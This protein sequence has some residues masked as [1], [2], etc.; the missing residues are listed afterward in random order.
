MK[1]KHLFYS[2]ALAG[3]FA[4]CTQDELIE[5]PVAE[6]NVANRPVAG[7][8]EFTLGDGVDSRFNYEKQNGFEAGDVFGLYLMDEYVGNYNGSND[9]YCPN[10]HPNANDPYWKYQNH[11]WA[12]Y[13]LTNNIQSNYPFTATQDGDDL[14][15]K[16]DAKLVEGNYFAM[17]PQNDLALN[18]RELWRVIDAEVELKAHSTKDAIFHNVENQFWLG[19]QQIYRDATASAESVLKMNVKMSNVLV[20]L[21]FK[22][23]NN[24]NNTVILD[25]ISFVNKLGRHLPTL[26]YVEPAGRNYTNA[27]G[28]EVNNENGYT[29]PSWLVTS[30]AKDEFECSEAKARYLYDAEKTWT[31]ATIQ[32]IVRWSVPG[33]EAG[34]IPYGLTGELA[35]PAY[36]YSFSYP[37]DAALLPGGVDGGYLLTTYLVVPGLEDEAQWKDLMVRV[38]G[39][40]KDNS[41]T[42]GWTYGMLT[43]EMKDGNTA[44][45][46]FTFNLYTALTADKEQAEETGYYR[47]VDIKFQEFGWKSIDKRMEVA[48]TDEMEKKVLAHLSQVAD[49]ATARIKIA[50]DADGIEITKA[51]V[52]ALSKDSEDNGHVIE[53]EF[54]GDRGG[55][56]IFNEDNTL[57][58]LDYTT[59][60]TVGE[61]D[62]LKFRYTRGI[63]LVNNAVQTIPAGYTVE[64]AIIR[65][66]STGKLNVEGVIGAIKE[67]ESVLGSVINEGEMVVTGTI[68][69]NVSNDY[70]LTLKK[71]SNL[72]TVL[73]NN[74]GATTN[75]E[76]GDGVATVNELYNMGEYECS[77]C[78]GA[79]LNVVNGTLNVNYLQ[80]GSEDSVAATLEVA[81]GAILTINE[82]LTN[83]SDIDW[84]NNEWIENVIFNNNG[85]IN[86]EGFIE[87]NG[88]INNYGDINCQRI[89]NAEAAIINQN[90]ATVENGISCQLNNS[91]IIN[92]YNGKL[93][94]LKNNSVGILNVYTKTVEVNT[95][96]QSKGEI[97]FWGVDPEHIGVG[98]NDYRSFR[99]IKAMETK[100]LFPMMNRT[101]TDRLY[102]GY[103]LTLTFAE[104][105]QIASQITLIKV[106]ANAENNKV[107]ITGAMNGEFAFEKAYLDVLSG[108]QLHIE[109]CIEVTI[110]DLNDPFSGGQ[111]HVGS[112]SKLED[113]EGE[114]ITKH[115]SYAE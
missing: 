62:K 37:K 24:S 100:E 84:V 113:P 109:N 59:E 51:F 29:W 54:S 90:G 98:G 19:Y 53:L 22:L 92:A 31:R 74:A 35:R 95:T 87:N 4:A 47:N 26:A 96:N 68:N 15:W 107:N 105:N 106:F 94:K 81:K 18:R 63:S 30:D 17:F 101:A 12:M 52:E 8:V 2:L 39:W 7:V 88:T 55:K 79:T 69:V 72:T 86:G 28:D 73:L 80:N 61:S 9:A 78:I 67:N 33:A 111:I 46:N 41:S 40:Y 97:I 110:K 6:N 91:G 114:A 112:N 16:N 85:T 64:S 66:A 49:G 115:T 71:G 3:I 43:P 32:E 21:R 23:N 38:Y 50:P 20:P 76:A 48:S 99:T 65:N 83:Y 82:K 104:G 108:K 60:S 77:T 103:D 13:Q 70:K 56:V 5:A 75:V 45:D 89:A 102:L 57:A 14:A 93:L 27:E 10:E 34:R 11:W 58:V 1:T 36:E 44:D 42:T 25:K